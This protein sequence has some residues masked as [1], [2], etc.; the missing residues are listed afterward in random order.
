MG[1]GT[2][3]R[4]KKKTLA[5]SD[6]GMVSTAS[7]IATEAGVEILQ[8][9]GNAI[10]AAVAAA[11]CLGVTEPQASGLGGQ[12]M[13]LL[14]MANA[15]TSVAVDGSSRSPFSINP[16]NIPSKRLKLG[17]KA[18]TVPST[19]ATLGYLLETYGRL[20]IEE[21]L[22]P[23]IR[24]AREGYLITA[25][26]HRLLMKEREHLLRDRLAS[27]IFFSNGNALRAGERL[28]QKSLASTL[29]Q[30]ASSGWRDF[31]HGQIAEK[32]LT[33]MQEQ[34]GYFTEIDL[35]QIP[36]PIERPVL[37][38]TYR[39]LKIETFPPPGAGR[40]LVQI[41][42]ILETFEPEELDLNKTQA[43]LILALAFRAALRDRERMP[44]DP[45][46]YLQSTNQLMVDKGYAAEITDRIKAIV[47]RIPKD[48]LCA[49]PK[50]SGETTHLSVADAEGNMIG[51]TQSIELV[52]GSKTMAQELG[53]FY[54]NYMSAYN[55]E[56]MTHPHYFLPGTAPWSSVAP[57]LVYENNKPRLLLGSPGSERIAT[58][59]VQVISRVFDAG[60][61]LA[62]AIAAPRLHSSSSQKVQIE[63]ERFCSETIEHLEKAGFH[64]VK[65]GAYS[66]YLGCVQAILLPHKPEQ[67]FVGVADIRR[68]G[69][70][71]GM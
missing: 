36:I 9:G 56:D 8:R 29:E 49:P 35:Q 62:T 25:L 17:I 43:I 15:E 54:N 63:K 52:F 16:S 57:T 66:F 33:D 68:D 7:T 44:I 71:K 4:Q 67:K 45:A 58:S 53:F 27:S 14:K 5:M 2:K 70:A 48:E 55:Y 38:G 6:K 31:Y 64:I 40:A 42:N 39:G 50:T 51:I 61:D 37:E 41:L 65:R 10:D 26:Q 60:E 47:V 19:P 23:A 30:M 11:F 24:A 28:V 1:S 59:L 34:G 18:T 32:I 20:T 3:T 21:V 69:S 12:S 13:A 22:Q 46:R